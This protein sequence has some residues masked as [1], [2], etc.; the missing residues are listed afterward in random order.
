MFKTFK[1]TSTNCLNVLSFSCYVCAHI[2]CFIWFYVFLCNVCL[3]HFNKIS[4][5]WNISIKYL[6]IYNIEQFNQRLKT[7]LFISV[8]LSRSKHGC[9]YQE[10]DCSVI[11]H[12]MRFKNCFA[13]GM[14]T[15]SQCTLFMVQTLKLQLR[16]DNIQILTSTEGNIEK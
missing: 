10:V 8:F 9:I 12:K 5:K 7:F 16:F 13:V 3:S 6:F 1:H 15:A 2:S 14:K 11:P 4:I